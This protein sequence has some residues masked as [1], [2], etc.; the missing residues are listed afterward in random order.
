M[1]VIAT[2]VGIYGSTKVRPGKELEIPDDEP[3]RSW[4]TP[5]KGYEAPAPAADEPTTLGALAAPVPGKLKG[6]AVGQGKKA[7]AAEA[8]DL[9]D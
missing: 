2:K 5:A 3:L 1:K 9:T 6:R 4:M 7:P 8:N